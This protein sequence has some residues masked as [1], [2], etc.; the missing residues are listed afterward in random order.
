MGKP[1]ENT[2]MMGAVFH[3]KWTD[4]GLCQVLQ[5]P[6]GKFSQLCFF[7]EFKKFVDPIRLRGRGSA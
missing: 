2:I 3:L 1:S 7:R 4:I 5:T 6:L